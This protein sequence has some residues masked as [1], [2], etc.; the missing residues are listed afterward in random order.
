MTT[1]RGLPERV[2]RYLAGL[3]G[4]RI[5][6]RVDRRAVT[7]VG[8]LMS[9]LGDP[10]LAHPVI[11]VTGTNGKGSTTAMIAALLRAEGLRVGAYTSPHLEQITERVSFDNGPMEAERFADAVDRTAAVA[12]R[13][14]ITPTW[15]EAVTAASFLLLGEAPLDVCVIEVGMLGR[16]DATNVVHGTVAVVTN[17]ELDHTERAGP[18]RSAI[19]YEK[20]GIVEPGSTLVLG[21]TDPRLRHLF[22][23]RRPESILTRDHE[24]VAGQTTGG[25]YG[26]VLDLATPWAVHRAVTVGLAGEHQCDNALLA[27]GAAEAYLQR[28]MATE[29][30]DRALTSARVPG[31]L[32]IVQDRPT[33]V[34]DG[35][36]NPAGAGA[37][38]RATSRLFA[39]AAPRVFVCG[40][41]A[42]R[43]AAAFLHEL[44]IAPE[45]WLIATEPRAPQAMPAVALAE[46]ALRLGV[47]SVV[48][49]DVSEALQ[50]AIR[51]AG[52]GGIVIGT[53]SH[54]LVA[55]F[56]AAVSHSDG[57]ARTASG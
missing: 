10:H 43:S 18:T 30:V 15:F 8:A 36:H 25:P 40:M 11:H 31:R 14:R 46:A 19:A 3:P 27:V 44:S 53:G 41:R 17:V 5:G 23:A 34:I 55:A 51:I 13:R 7:R 39:G 16:V 49:P 57:F 32:E 38:A 42:G 33:V 20:A 50:T 12:R 47:R 21:E 2:E 28:P 52:A 6:S 4:G 9:A 37:L 26:S 22:E 1:E 29:T 45:G 48:I 24:L 54:Y 56:R 35:A